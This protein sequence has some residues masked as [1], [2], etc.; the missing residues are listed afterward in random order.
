[1]V[2]YRH[3]ISRSIPP[4]PNLI[5]NLS[6]LLA[7]WSCLA[8]IRSETTTKAT[9]SCTCATIECCRKLSRL[10]KVGTHYCEIFSK[11]KSTT[12][13]RIIWNVRQERGTCLDAKNITEGVPT[14]L[15]MSTNVHMQN[16]LNHMAAKAVSTCTSRTNTMEVTRQIVKRSRNLL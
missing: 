2:Q 4:E 8:M 11:S 6:T 13:M 3:R 12:T 15:S 5:K 10:Q 9:G 16:A 14:K 1:M 7:L